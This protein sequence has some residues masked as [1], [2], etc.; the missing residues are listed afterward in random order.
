M[1]EIQGMQEM[2]TRIVR[3]LNAINLTFLQLG[4]V[5]KDP[6]KCSRRFQE[7]FERIPGNV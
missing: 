6:E 4:I 3:N 1:R 7:M 2:F 5:Q